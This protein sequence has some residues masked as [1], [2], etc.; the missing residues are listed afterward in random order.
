MHSDNSDRSKID[1]LAIGDTVVDAFIRLNVAHENLDIDH[2]TR[3]LSM[4][5]GDKVPYEFKKVVSGVGNS[6]NA[7]VAASRLG[8]QTAILTDVGDD[9]YGKDCID[10]FIANGVS[11]KYV[12]THKGKETNYHYV[13]WFHSDRTILIKHEEYDYSI[14]NMEM[15]R[16]IYLSSLSEHSLEFHKKLGEYLKSNPDIKLAFQ[17]GTFQMKFGT[18][19]LKD[20]YE[21]TEIFFCNIEEAQRILKTDISVVPK[22]MEMI[23]ELG[24]RIVVIT[25]GPNGSYALDARIHKKYFLKIYQD[26][27]PPYERT[28]AG[29]AFSST[30]TCAL[31]QGLDIGTAM[32]WG[33]INSMSVVQYIAA[34]EGL[35]HK[36]ELDLY[37]KDA[38]S[39]WKVEII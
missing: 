1:F 26:P 23:S 29:D 21:R 10:N 20:I 3:I 12:K 18:E 32:Q 7:A 11:S 5:F 30:F 31:T 6:A 13:L 25:D 33:S 9:M 8:L 39:D 38:P 22:L 28:G 17:P 19:A 15:P 14:P 2:H 24:P 36:N 27:K 16:W 34:Q 4:N 37:L 35:L